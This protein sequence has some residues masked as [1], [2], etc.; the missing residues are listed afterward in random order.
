MDRHGGIDPRLNTPES[1]FSRLKVWHVHN[2]GVFVYAS[3]NVTIES[4]VQRSDDATGTGIEFS[5]YYARNLTIRRANIQGRMNRHQRHAEHGGTTILIEDSLLINQADLRIAMLG[6]VSARPPRNSA[7]V[8][9]SSEIQAHADVP[10][11][12]RSVG[13][14]VLDYSDK[15]T[16]AVTRPAEILG[17]GLQRR[18]GRHLQG[19]LHAA[20]GHLRRAGQHLQ[21]RRLAQA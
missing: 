7:N 15:P 13:G 21:R 3:N 18:G 20:G 2:K 16:H 17:A 12:G 5:D 9:G 1:V 4:M 19:V 10:R 14:I 11:H 6:T 8:A